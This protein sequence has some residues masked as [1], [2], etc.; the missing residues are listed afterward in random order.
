MKLAIDGGKKS[1][2]GLLRPYNHIGKDEATAAAWAVRRGPLSGYLGG[3]RKGGYYVEALELAFCDRFGTRH[4]VACNS[5]TSGL[6]IALM[7]CRPGIRLVTV[8]NYTMSAT[9]AVPLFYGMEVGLCDVDPIT[10]CMMPE[11]VDWER[12]SVIIPTNLFGCPAELHKLRQLADEYHI[13]MIEDNA[14]GILAMEGGRYAGTIGHIGVFSLNVHK[15][16]HCG[17]GGVCLTD[18]DELAERMRMARNHGEL[19]GGNVG[20]NLR[21]TEV[22]AAIALV[23]MEK[24]DAL[25]NRAINQAHFLSNRIKPYS[26][27]GL[28]PPT[29][30]HPEDRHVYYMWA[31]TATNRKWF[32]EAM[33]AEGFPIRAGYVTP[34]NR[35]PAFKGCPYSDKNVKWLEDE[36]LC[37]FENCAYDFTAAERKQIKDAFD[38]VGEAYVRRL[39]E[40]A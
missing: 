6:L 3:V 9:A 38:K 34:L 28:V 22:S 13:P 19:A 37:T 27:P 7:A 29:Q 30:K 20:L 23:Q 11:A 4:A 26:G 33:N 15:H 16:I 21:M 2:P 10:Y 24:L 31:P 5:A 12:S 39:S 8:P 18:D 32:V 1:I 35:L 25:V 17:E 40:A 14:Q 36:V